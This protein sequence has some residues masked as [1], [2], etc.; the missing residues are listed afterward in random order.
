MH[1]LCPGFLT[2]NF[3]S[4]Y[5]ASE[6]E[7]I[8]EVRAAGLASSAPPMMSSFVFVCGGGG[9]TPWLS[10]ELSSVSGNANAAKLKLI[11]PTQHV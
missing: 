7:P 5:S 1:F 3:K 11:K 2:F 4:V 9:V 6:P 8:K 10:V